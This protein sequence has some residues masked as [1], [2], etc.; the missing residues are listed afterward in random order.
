[1]LQP[2][3]NPTDLAPGD[4]KSATMDWTGFELH[5][6]RS[7]DDPLFPAAFDPLWREFHAGNEIEQPDVIARRMRWNPAQL[8][9]GI[10]LLY[11]MLLVTKDGEFI[12]V[13]DQTAIVRP[14][15]GIAVVHLS[16]NLV[17]PAHRRSGIA[18]WLRALPIQTARDC[19]AA[20]QL[21]TGSQIYLIG[22]MEPADPANE[23][24]TIRLIAYE[25]AGYRKVDPAALNYLQPDFRS[26]AEIDASGAPQ[27]VPLNL[28][29]RKVGR[30]NEP[31]MRAENIHRIA[32]CLYEMYAMEFRPQ[33]MEVVWRNLETFPRGEQIV[34]L[35]PPTDL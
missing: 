21:P 12:G 33:D 19:L 18:G 11:E 20:Q 10:A 25:K 32:H 22:E 30:E 1:M 4:A 17:A 24:R 14:E 5:R 28:L 16:H 9:N 23:A 2:W 3:M 29:V 8:T 31:S 15:F 27:P 26:P 7:I 6:I 13:R 34:P 35:L